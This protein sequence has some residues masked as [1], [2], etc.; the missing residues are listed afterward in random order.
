MLSFDDGY[1]NNLRALPLLEKF[2]VPALFYIPAQLVAEGRAF[3]WD[4]LYRSHR[5]AG[6]SQ[7]EVFADIARRAPARTEDIEQ[8]L[9]RELGVNEFKAV[10][11]TDRLFTPDELRQFAAHPLV[12]IG[13]HGCVHEH[14]T[15][16]PITEAAGRIKKAQILL[17]EMTN[18]TPQAIAYPYGAWS[19]A[20]VR[21]ALEAGLKLGVTTVLQKEYVQR[22]AKG[23]QR[24][25]LGRFTVWGDSDVPRQC[26]FMRG[27]LMISARYRG[28]ISRLKQHA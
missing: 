12:R 4:I 20:V 16:Y 3:W 8:Q 22:L 7:P 9:A 11:D 21:A 6:R 5:R 15:S 23:Q 18:Q 28:T 19:D 14:L 17:R 13:N 10:S 1:F 26:R 25:Q 2:Q 27:D 24:M